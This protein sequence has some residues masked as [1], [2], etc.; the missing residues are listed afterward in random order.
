MG[1]L[2]GKDE[3]YIIDLPA[4]LDDGNASQIAAK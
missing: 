1:I 3:C 4:I 2:S